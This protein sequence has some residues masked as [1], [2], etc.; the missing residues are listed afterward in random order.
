M[1]VVLY[2]LITVTFKFVGKSLF[3]K[4]CVYVSLYN[5]LLFWYELTDISFYCVT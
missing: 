2:P 1:G 5:V 4:Y 3:Y